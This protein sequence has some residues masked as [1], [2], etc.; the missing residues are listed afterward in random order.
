MDICVD[1][2]GTCVTHEFPMTGA[3]IGAVPILK[4]LV[5]NGH[6]L[7]LFTMRS[8]GQQYPNVM[9]EAV[10]WFEDNEIPLFGIN[11]NPEQKEWTE[12][13]KAYGEL[14]IDD[15]ALGM[16]LK[17]DGGISARPFVDWQ[18]ASQMLWEKHCFVKTRGIYEPHWDQK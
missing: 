13:P 16:P 9:T 8:E 17:V 6:R 5:E 10:K 14:Y 15:A 2:D 18:K 3:D 11:E 12:S 4:E 1:F 7:V